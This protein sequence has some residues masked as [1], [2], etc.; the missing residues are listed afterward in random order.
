MLATAL[1]AANIEDLFAALRLPH[2]VSEASE[3]TAIL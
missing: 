1:G 3:H 2:C